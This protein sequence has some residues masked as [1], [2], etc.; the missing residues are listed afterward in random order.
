MATFKTIVK[1]VRPD[2]FYPVYIRVIQDRKQLNIK[3]GLLVHKK[4]VKKGDIKDPV[5]VVECANRIK[6]YIDLLN[7]QRTTDWGVYE[8]VDY[9]E[10]FSKDISFTDFAEKYIGKL[11][12]TGH[13]RN[14]RNYRAA[15]KS[16]V[17]YMGTDKIMFRMITSKV[18]TGFIEGL[19]STCRAK[20]MYPVCLKVMFNA[21]CD[22]YN[23]YD[24]GIMQIKNQP[25]RTIKIPKADTPQKRSIPVE[26]LRKILLVQPLLSC[27]L[28][29]VELGR[30]VFI[31]VFCL[32]GINTVDLYF[33][34]PENLKGNKLC[35]NRSKT[36]SKREDKAYLEIEIPEVVRPLFNKYKDPTGERLLVFH[37]LYCNYDSFTANAN[38]HLKQVC[39]IA[40]IEKVDGYA[41]RHTWATLAQ[42]KCEA[43]TAEVA[44]ALNHASAHKVTE[45]YIDKDF[46]PIDRLNKKV[47]EYCFGEECHMLKEVL[48]P[49]W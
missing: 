13:E 3:T 4:D 30:D 42:N 38:G 34:K 16:F 11:I 29:R 15:L 21:A 47:L 6:G 45:G 8:I 17:A 22:E 39:Q 18:I 23:D 25:F 10:N 9:L 44:F 20:E 41:F 32:A 40:G 35:Y 43:T 31:M 19:L 36:D 5:V 1:T 26:Q 14:A 48:S 27:K 46:T 37:K 2:G 28:T 33:L 7:T 24:R 49:K 12:N